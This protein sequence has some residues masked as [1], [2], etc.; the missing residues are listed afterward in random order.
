MSRTAGSLL[1]ALLAPDFEAPT[2]LHRQIYAK[3][4][5]A[6]LAGRIAPGA[7]IPATRELAR[8]LGVGRNTVMHAVEQLVTEGYLHATRGA[9]TFVARMLPDDSARVGPRPAARRVG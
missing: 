4:R 2:A 7:Q 8:E 6:I 5:A 3:L 1:G 9:G